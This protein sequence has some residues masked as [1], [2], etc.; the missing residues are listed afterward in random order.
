[1]NK[2]DVKWEAFIWDVISVEEIINKLFTSISTT[3][4]DEWELILIKLMI[5]PHSLS[6]LSS[7]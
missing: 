5:Q 3:F 1:M 6:S 2:S 4:G 7:K